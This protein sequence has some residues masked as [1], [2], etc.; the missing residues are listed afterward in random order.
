M[1]TSAL[2][3]AL[4]AL[5]NMGA[6]IPKNVVAKQNELFR[7]F[8]GTEFVWKFDELPAKGTIP[9][10]RVPYSGYIYPD[11]AG[12]TSSA[13]RKY[14][15]AFNGGRP[16]AT[17]VEQ[18]DTTAFKE[19]SKRRS[20]L[21][22][23]RVRTVMETPNWHGHCNGWAAA[24]IRHAEPEQS[25]RRNGVVFTPADI[26]ALLAEIYM[27][28]DYEYLAGLHDSINA[29][30][31]H[32]ILGNWIGRGGHPLGMEADPGPQKWNYPLYGYASSSAR[33]SAREVEVKLNLLYA[34]DSNTEYQENPRI[35]RVKYFHYV[36]T[37]DDNGEI[38]GGRYFGD[39][40]IIDMVWVPLR[41][42]QGGS[43]GNESGNRHVDVNQVLSLWRESVSEEVRK[44]WPVV[45]PPVED[46]IL[47]V[48][49]L[50]TLVPVQDVDAARNRP[51]VAAMERVH[52][53]DG[54]SHRSPARHNPN[55]TTDVAREVPDANGD[56]SEPTADG[57]G[58][59][60]SVED[61]N[62]GATSDETPSQPEI[63][64]PRIAPPQSRGP[65]RID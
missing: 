61:R 19:P 27:Y 8:W 51:P 62:G 48:A 15:R 23:L 56:G 16:L 37:L 14:D 53:A 9:S 25:V 17:A 33:R 44:K 52:S 39:S 58:S 3:V 1:A 2:M 10:Y 41:P 59:Q 40:S 12:G 31:L 21:F 34:K 22:G 29:G 30:V 7:Q 43:K 28:N 60:P 35:Q 20:G 45:D 49:A 54:Y 5:S 26:K 46:R 38:T 36:L 47:N 63:E 4:I 50:D 6:P 64:G 24:A 57:T 11:R 65:A 18:W 55:A 13:L 42:K 32:A